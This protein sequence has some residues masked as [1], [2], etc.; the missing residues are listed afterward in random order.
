MKTKQTN[1]KQENEKLINNLCLNI[2]ISILFFF[3]N[4]ISIFYG[5][6]NKIRSYQEMIKIS[7]NFSSS[8]T[9]NSFQQIISEGMKSEKVII[10]TS[11]KQ[12]E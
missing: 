6:I 3:I 8:Q 5:K 11:K 2:F 10:D 1:F 7:T 4:T 12:K 9:N